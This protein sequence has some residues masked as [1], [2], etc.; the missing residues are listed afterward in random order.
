MDSAS[1]KEWLACGTLISTQE[2]KLQLGW[3]KRH[4][5]SAPSSDPDT[6][7][8][9]FPDFFLHTSRPWFVHEHH[10]E[11]DPFQ[12]LLLLSEFHS[13]FHEES[14]EE[15]NSHL[16]WISPDR[17]F[18]E[19]IFH[20]IQT[21]FAADTLK[22]AVPFVF[23]TAESTLSK[24][25]LVRSLVS[26]IQY[27]THNHSHIYGFWDHEEGILGV[28]PELLFR[29]SAPNKLETVACAGTIRSNED[30]N[31][32]LTDQK[33]IKEHQIVVE[34]IVESLTASI[35]TENLNVGEPYILNLPRLSHLVTSITLTLTTNVS[36]DTIVKA[37]HP[38]PALGAFPRQEG[39]QWL[40][41]YNKKIKRLRFGAPVGYTYAN[42]KN[43]HCCVAIRNV[44]WTKH[45]LTIGA[46]CGIIKESQCHQ[47]WD[48]ILLKLQA[49]KEFLS[50]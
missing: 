42:L 32:I 24:S 48:E 17:C 34:G 37:L 31:E 20:E 50:L 41:D 7:S 9:Y 4:W 2:K 28:T 29:F 19:T 30:N 21:E 45:Q 49:T 39:M 38:T 15:A 6:P 8:F 13:E 43:A 11:I 36:F 35:T 22:K 5:Q 16:K 3:G 23:E 33:L 44:Q 12:L 1:F 40:L 27:F 26:S 47:E 14:H 46:G 25:Q 18:F 10:A